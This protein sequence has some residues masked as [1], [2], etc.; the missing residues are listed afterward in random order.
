MWPAVLGRVTFGVTALFAVACGSPTQPMH[1]SSPASESSIVVVDRATTKAALGQRV[2]VHGTAQDA[3]LGPVVIA[4]DLVV[5]CFMAG[6]EQWPGELAGKPVAAVG[7][8]EETDEFT[9]RT[10][11]GGEVSAGTDGPV[12]VLRNCTVR[13]WRDRP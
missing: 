9:A 11:S 2:T 10:G 6:V 12:L 5:Y 7:T 4:R 8:L 1:G 3:K 13:E